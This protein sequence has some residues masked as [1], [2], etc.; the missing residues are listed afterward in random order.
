MTEEWATNKK[1]NLRKIFLSACSINLVRYNLR[2]SKYFKLQVYE[3]LSLTMLLNSL[4][5][6]FP[7]LEPLT[8]TAQPH[9]GL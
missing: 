2:S 4:N 7:E 9:V 3:I 8:V 5:S 6:T 1:L